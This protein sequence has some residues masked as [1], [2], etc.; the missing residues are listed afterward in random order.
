M[1][2]R[3]LWFCRWT[4]A[5]TRCCEPGPAARAE[6]GWSG[7]KAEAVA[8]PSGPVQPEKARHGQARPNTDRT[9]PDRTGTDRTG[10]DRPGPAR[11]ETD[12]RLPATS[13]SRV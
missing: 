7:R 6:L 9:G 10:Q 8:S 13:G 11:P 2:W 3:L 12:V 1:F 4:R 5:R